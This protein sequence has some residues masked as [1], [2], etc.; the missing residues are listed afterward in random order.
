MQK[1]LQIKEYLLDEELL[2]IAKKRFKR[3][4][5]D[6]S[7]MFVAFIGKI[8]ELFP[9]I[10]SLVGK[11]MGGVAKAMKAGASAVRGVKQFGRD[12]G[13]AGF[14][15]AKNSSAKTNKRVSLTGT[16]L[17]MVSS[18][19]DYTTENEKAYSKVENYFKKSGCST[20]ELYLHTGHTGEQVDYILESLKKRS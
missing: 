2:V 10:G 5:F 15:S 18:L 1:I 12:H 16:M 20:E 3:K 6:T 7:T 8:A 9:G 11:I 19:P 17:D 14:N 13:V 4:V